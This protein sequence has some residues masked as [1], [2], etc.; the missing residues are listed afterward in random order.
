MK[1]ILFIIFIA[2][3]LYA[4]KPEYKANELNQIPV[5]AWYSIPYDQ[6][7]LRRY[8]ELKDAG[9]THNLSFFPDTKTMH[10]AF[11]TAALAGI[12][13]V[14]YCPELKTKTEETV[15]LFKNHPALAAYM[16]RDEPNRKDFPELGD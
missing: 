9:F 8:Q 7:S 3:C 13:M 10:A 12:K 11:D 1:N 5:L 15:K 14:A 6:T 4:C 2:T 16:L